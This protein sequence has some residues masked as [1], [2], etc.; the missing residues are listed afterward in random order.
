MRGLNLVTGNCHA[1]FLGGLEAAMPPGY[2]A[3]KDEKETQCLT[4]L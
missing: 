4:D 1:G 3:L 2:P